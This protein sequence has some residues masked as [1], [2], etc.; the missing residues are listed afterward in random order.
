MRTIST[1]A[2]ALTSLAFMTIAVASHAQPLTV[3]PVNAPS[4]ACASKYS[5]PLMSG[6]SGI[7]CAPAGATAMSIPQS[8]LH[9]ACERIIAT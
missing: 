5:T 3:V 1:L 4:V 2:F 8:A 9:A 6:R 7:A